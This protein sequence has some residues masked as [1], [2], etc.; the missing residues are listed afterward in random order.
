MMALDIYSAFSG[1]DSTG[2]SDSRKSLKDAYAEAMADNALHHFAELQ[3]DSLRHQLEQVQAG[4]VFDAAGKVDSDVLSLFERDN[5]LT[6]QISAWCQLAQSADLTKDH[7]LDSLL[8]P[9]ERLN[10]EM[11]AAH[12]APSRGESSIPRYES[13]ILAP[14]YEAFYRQRG[15]G[16]EAR[17]AHESELHQQIRELKQKVVMKD[18][19]IARLEQKAADDQSAKDREY[20]TTAK[21]FVQK[22]LPDMLKM[23]EAGYREDG[24]ILDKSTQPFR[25]IHLAKLLRERHKPGWTD[26]TLKQ[27]ISSVA[28]AHGF[29]FNAG[30]YQSGEG[31]EGLLMERLRSYLNRKPATAPVE[32]V[33]NQVG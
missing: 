30:R 9:L 4:S 7:V 17:E 31:N 18:A 29:Y 21:G 23:I 1:Y 33:K 15:R 19:K 2:R 6:N 20:P 24:L 10:R 26:S 22:H 13:S 32:C 12:C 11:S 16:K 25:T 14:T 28:A 3:R 27:A 5:S 8:T